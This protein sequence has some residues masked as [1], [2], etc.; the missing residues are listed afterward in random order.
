MKGCVCMGNR[1]TEEM[2]LWL[3]DL[4]H[5]N[6]TDKQI[7][8]GFI[9]HYVLCDCGIRDVQNNMHFHTTYSTEQQESALL[10]LRKL[11]ENIENQEQET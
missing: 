9:K 5:D 2:K 7:L 1:Y 6:L 8:Q 4:A 3:F 10:R 11:L